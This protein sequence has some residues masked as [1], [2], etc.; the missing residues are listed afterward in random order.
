[1][2]D[3]I[4]NFIHHKG[5]SPILLLSL[6]YS[7]LLLTLS[8]SL[9]LWV[10]LLGLCSCVARLVA[11]RQ[12]DSIPKTRTVNLLAVLS[13]FALS[14][15]GL[16]IGLLDSMLNLLA[17]ACALKLIQLNKKRDFHLLICTCLFLI[18]CGFISALSIFAWFGYTGVLVLLLLA[19]AAYHGPQISFHR[20]LKFVM[21]IVLQGLPIA[22]LLFL[23]LPQLPPLWQ[24]P[25]SKSSKTGLAE[26]V[27]PGDIAS[28]A[29][30]SELA[31][32]ATFQNKEDVP[33]MARRYWRAMVMEN[34]DGKTW[35]IDDK[36]KLAERQLENLGKT[37]K[38]LHL[39]ST[40][41]I[42]A[43]AYEM[44]VE[45]TH[46]TW[47]YGL[48]L[49]TPDNSKNTTFVRQRHDHTLQAESAIT[50]KKQFHLHYLPNLT[51]PNSTGEFEKQLN[52]SVA[53]NSNPETQ[54]W[55]NELKVHYQDPM[56]IAE[57][58]M[59]YFASQSF[60]YTLSPNPMPSNPVDTFLFD[61]QAGFCAH[62]AGAMAFALRAADIP[63]R[64]VAGYHGGELLE[65]NV[66]QIRQYDA[67]AWVEVLIDNKWVRYD[68]TSMAAPSRI[69]RGLEQALLDFG[70]TREQG[71]LRDFTQSG[72]ITELQTWLRHLD[73][74]WSK[75][76]LGFDANSQRDIFEE[77]LGDLNTTKITVAFLSAFLL[78][79]FIL[80]LY[81]FPFKHTS[82][83]P[84]YHR[85]YLKTLKLLEQK[86]GIKRNNQSPLA[87]TQQ[88]APHL[89]NETRT[90][91]NELNTYYM[92]VVY[93]GAIDETVANE[94]MKVQYKTLKHSLN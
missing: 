65:D 26:T 43:I 24:M 71:F 59:G 31:F 36:R 8:E 15:F 86:T 20:H 60:R 66:L 92:K 13:I 85:Y 3:V 45:P 28:L 72:L 7:I 2:K 17:I 82:N 94:N 11:V 73:Y 78:V 6:A 87:Y 21:L 61:E 83:Q 39:S 57:A 12:P 34:F 91:I 63:A 84:Q 69:T 5:S 44:I 67:H 54:K 27:T 41:E 9:M 76:V 90:I 52:L 32:T 19:T 55:A 74:S 46:Q 56:R 29:Q 75:W 64:L 50:S 89:N 49:S 62:Y 40:D 93:Q 25:T 70:E 16:S 79:G 1:M 4:T 30:S 23:V 18:G 42:S 80:L 88:I 47:L 58:I 22:F 14:W 77:L 37:P 81:F 10:L 53:R 48:T 35:A 51:V 33:V 68:P 38:S